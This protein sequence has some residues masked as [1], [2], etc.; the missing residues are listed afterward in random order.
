MVEQWNRLLTIRIRNVLPTHT[1][2]NKN[3]FPLI[4]SNFRLTPLS[5][6]VTHDNVN[7]PHSK[8]IKIWK[9]STY[10][11][12]NAPYEADKTKMAASC[13]HAWNVTLLNN[14]GRAVRAGKSSKL[15][16]IVLN[17][18]YGHYRSIH[19]ILYFFGSS[20]SKTVWVSF[21]MLW[22]SCETM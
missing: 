17:R 3:I 11:T 22:L 2:G 1:K 16:C 8:M 13:H 12:K 18:G 14:N 7:V 19:T 20:T 4:R 15:H 5:M 21:L 10:A 6:P 9:P